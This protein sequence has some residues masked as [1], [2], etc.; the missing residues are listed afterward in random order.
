MQTNLISFIIRKTMFESSMKLFMVILHL[1]SQ[2]A[3]ALFLSVKTFCP[4]SNSQ[5]LHS[6][7]CTPFHTEILKETVIYFTILKETVIYEEIFAVIS[8]DAISLNDCAM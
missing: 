4:F 2:C 5:E 8:S 1:M 3:P 7:F 6:L